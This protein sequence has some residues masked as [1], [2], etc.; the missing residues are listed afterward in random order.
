MVRALWAAVLVGIVLV[1]ASAIRDRAGDVARA[2]LA[3]E[4]TRQ[5]VNRAEEAEHALAA[6]MVQEDA[7]ILL[8]QA[9]RDSAVARA[10][11]AE[12][13]RPTIIER[14]VERAGPDSAIVRAAVLEVVDSIEAHEMTP[15]RAALAAAT[16]SEAARARQLYAALAAN[17]ALRTALDASQAEAGVWKAAVG[18]TVFGVRVEPEL[19]FVAGALATA[20]GVAWM[21]LR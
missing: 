7:L 8:A 19:A 9:E 11:R 18:G 13:R 2:E 12:R 1:A 21:V 14:V 10:D 3:A 20:G 6:V 17:A 16:E 4:E 15:L 5:A